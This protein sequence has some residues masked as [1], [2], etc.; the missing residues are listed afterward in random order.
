MQFDN[1]KKLGAAA[2]L[3]AGVVSIASIGQSLNSQPQ[4]TTS[5][6]TKEGYSQVEVGDMYKC[7][8]GATLNRNFKAKDPRGQLVEG[9]AC[10]Y[11]GL[12]FI[13]ATPVKTPGLKL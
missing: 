2:L 12:K 3:V 9:H 1:F 13:S 11:F 6:L 5:Y 10:G 7:G 4:D 8:K